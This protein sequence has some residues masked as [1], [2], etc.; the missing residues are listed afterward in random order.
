MPLLTTRSSKGYGWGALVGSVVGDFEA[1][2]TYT[3]G[4]ALN[5]VTF[6]SIP[7]TYVNL[8]MRI[9]AKTSSMG[10][11]AYWTYF[12]NDT[13]NTNYA[14]HTLGGDGTSFTQSSI[15]RPDLGA[16]RDNAWATCVQDFVDYTNT[17]NKK[18]R[19]AVS[20]VMGTPDGCVFYYSGA[21]N[22]T[23]AINRIDIRPENSS[24]NF[25]TGSVFALYGLKG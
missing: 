24:A 1:I 14:Y 18:V 11:S 5:T 7:S 20:S 9:F 12:N 19:R 22:N 4:T 23:A 17:S 10:N 21:W 25:I 8:Q 15:I 13:T 16:V 2:A 3:V 6:S